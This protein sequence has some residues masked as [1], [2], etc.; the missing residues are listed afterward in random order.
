MKTLVVFYS[1]NGTTKKVAEDISKRLRADIDE[2]IDLKNRKGVIGW[3]TSG[4]DAMKKNLTQIKE[5]KDPK[6]YD[7]VIIGSPV[8]AGSVSPGVRTFLEKNKGNFKKVIFFCT[9]GGGNPGKTFIQMSEIIKKKPIKTIFFKTSE[10]KKEPY[11]EELIKFLV[12]I[13]NKK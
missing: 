7:L 11:F 4:R 5:T 8:W 2:I 3:L 13:R 10:V 12:D 6:K 9:T 1:R